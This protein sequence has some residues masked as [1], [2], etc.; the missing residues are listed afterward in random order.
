MNTGRS[1]QVA[2]PAIT[3]TLTCLAWESTPMP[4]VTLP[5][6][7]TTGNAPVRGVPCL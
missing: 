3:L 6:R 4:R 1:G 2:W 5:E 7:G